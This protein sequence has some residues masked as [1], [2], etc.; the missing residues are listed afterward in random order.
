MPGSRRSIHV[1]PALLLLI[2]ILLHTLS[3]DPVEAQEPL[4]LSCA[5]FPAHLTEE[6]LRQRYGTGNVRTDSIFGMD[7]GPVEGLVVFPDSE[8]RR[9]EVFWHDPERKAGPIDVKAVGSAW[10]TPSGLS[11]GMDLLA[12]ERL[13]GWP[14]RLAGFHTESQGGVR[15]WGRGSIGD[16]LFW[17]D[18]E[19][20]T[21]SFKVHLQPGY[22]GSDDA[23]LM[24]QVRTGREYS[25]GHTAMQGL[26]PEVVAIWI[27]NR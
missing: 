11:I 3:P 23:D 5:A 17:E 25:S 19:A 13:N 14:F 8:D 20:R 16:R 9:L 27:R 2:P 22:D 26:N 7:D 18:P 24:R 10:R 1:H 21:C 6:D 12:V 15:S 4:E